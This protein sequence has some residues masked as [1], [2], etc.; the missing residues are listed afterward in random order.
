MTKEKRQ[1]VTSA[2]AEDGS[3]NASG[4]PE[5]GWGFK[6]LGKVSGEKEVEEIRAHRATMGR[7]KQ[8]QPKKSSG[9]KK[10]NVRNEMVKMLVIKD[11]RF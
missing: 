4:K 8:Y 11:F 6:V 10:N 7:R 2:S 3:F 5:E 9:S 1:V